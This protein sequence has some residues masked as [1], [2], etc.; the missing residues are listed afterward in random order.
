M[1]EET[2]F[3]Q[4]KISSETSGILW[5]TESDL[6]EKPKPFYALNYFFDGLLMNFFQRELQS[7]KMPNLFFTKNFNKNLFLGHY[8]IES[9]NIEKDILI[10]LDIVAN[11]TE[12]N[13]QILVLHPKAVKDQLMKKITKNKFFEFK[14]FNLS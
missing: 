3:L 14:A 2:P 4:D 5:L 10:F 1:I 12:K 13:S 11:L 6:K 7:D 9:S 8:C